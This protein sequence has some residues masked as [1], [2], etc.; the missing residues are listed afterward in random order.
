METDPTPVGDCDDSNPELNGL[1]VIAMDLVLV[2]E[3]VM[4][5]QPIYLLIPM[6]M[7]TQPATMTV[8]T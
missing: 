3:T 8:M 2:M 1:D 7:D 5:I 6:V 4:T